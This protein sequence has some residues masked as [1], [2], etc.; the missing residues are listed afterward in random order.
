MAIDFP[1]SPSINDT[2]L[3]GSVTYTW[4]GTK[5]TAATG[6]VSL[7]KIEVG[8]TK[9]EIVDTGSDGTFAVTTE[10]TQR[11]TVTS[12][13]NVGIGTTSPQGPLDLIADA[14][15]YGIVLRGRSSDN[16]GQLRF[17]SNNYASVYSELISTSS[18][19]AVTVN[20]LERARVDSSGRLLVGTT[21]ARTNILAPNATSATPTVQIETAASS[22]S[23]SLS[24]IN[25]NSSAF[26]PMLTLGQSNGTTVGSNTLVVNNQYFGVLAFS[27]SDGTNFI[28]GASIRGEVDGTPGA[29]DMPGRLVFST[30]ADGASSPTERMRI[31][32]TGTTS[33]ASGLSVGTL[34]NQGSTKIYLD[35]SVIASGAGTNALRYNNGTGVVTYDASSRLIKQEIVDCPYGISAVKQLK[36]RKYFRID[37]QQDEIGFIADE[38]VDILPEF[39]PTGPK[40]IITRDEI[41]T[42]IIPLGVNYD[43]LTAV[44]TKALQE[45]IA[46]IETLEAKVAAL[47]AQ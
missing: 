44:L 13:G 17:T 24:I 16:L 18:A 42:E 7:S 43:K 14:S 35:G 38:V 6:S 19:L 3:S 8:N 29:N 32:S 34:S 5:W 37:D 9:A 39:V 20:G 21:S 36:P 11:L 4:D 47:E 31:H 10:G 1:A 40:S 15:G 45:A 33:F 46:K 41:D 25:N 30:T 26:S 27:G 28:Q 2:F 12:T 23:N 22:Y